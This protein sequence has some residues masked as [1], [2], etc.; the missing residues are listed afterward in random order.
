MVTKYLSNA[1]LECVAHSQ[2]AGTC[3]ISRRP[4]WR[5]STWSAKNILLELFSQQVIVGPN[6]FHRH[7]HRFLATHMWE[8]LLLGKPSLVQ[9]VIQNHAS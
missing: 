7:L 9:F 4:R 1:L 2:T 5:P 6:D 3:H 8:N